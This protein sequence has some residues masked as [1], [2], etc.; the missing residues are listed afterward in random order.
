[1]APR[2]CS[3]G[4]LCKDGKYLLGLRSSSRNMYPNTWD[5]FGGHHE[6]G[7][8]IEDALIREFQE[9]LGITP[10]TYSLFGE[11]DEPN[12]DRYGKA[13]H[14][15]FFVT[16]WSGGSPRNISSE[17]SKIAWFSKNEMA[18]INLASE[19]YLDIVHGW[20]KDR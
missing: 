4:F 2:L 14:Y 19:I 6:K 10:T 5:I 20:E 9:E 16:G 13:V 12:P 18:Y 15:V 11:F 3:A 8:S 17:H 1:M 7:E